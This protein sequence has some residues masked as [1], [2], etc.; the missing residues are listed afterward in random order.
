MLPQGIEGGAF[1][2]EKKTAIKTT[3][4]LP[5]A[6]EAALREWADASEAAIRDKISEAVESHLEEVVA[7]LNALGLD[8][9]PGHQRPRRLNQAAWDALADGE[10]KTG[11]TR[12]L[13]LRCCLVQAMKKHKG[14]S[15]R[16]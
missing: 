16:R 12:S 5:K 7:A 8:G 6:V 15:K 10:Q 4:S 11:L 9:Q 14:Q 3:V 13:L 2:T 1:V